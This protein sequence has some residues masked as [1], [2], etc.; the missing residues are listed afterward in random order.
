[1][2]DIVQ[3]T[4]TISYFTKEEYREAKSDLISQPIPPFFFSGYVDNSK[5]LHLLNQQ[6]DLPAIQANGI[7]ILQHIND[8]DLT[9]FSV[10]GKKQ[11][12]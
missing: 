7:I 4:K 12:R 11:V 10:S 5:Q 1:M 9:N 8:P 3:V 2:I 6:T